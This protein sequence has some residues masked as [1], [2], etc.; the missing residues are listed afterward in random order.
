MRG[1]LIG[2]KGGLKGPWWDGRGWWLCGRV[3]CL[4]WAVG[5]GQEEKRKGWGNQRAK[6]C[7]VRAKPPTGRKS[8]APKI[9]VGS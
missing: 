3:V 9:G 4:G 7:Q 2:S 1:A 6:H 5:R 8:V